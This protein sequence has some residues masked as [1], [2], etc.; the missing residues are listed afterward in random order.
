MKTGKTASS[1]KISLSGF[2]LKSIKAPV[3]IPYMYVET[4]R[5][6]NPLPSPPEKAT[7]E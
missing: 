2:G 6:V 7:I 1:E 3:F 4:P 5:I